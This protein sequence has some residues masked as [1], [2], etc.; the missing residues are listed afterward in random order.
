MIYF[1]AIFNKLQPLQIFVLNT[2]ME[3]KNGNVEEHDVRG[4][5]GIVPKPAKCGCLVSTRYEGIS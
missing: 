4:L 2:L 5:N 3:P 1:L